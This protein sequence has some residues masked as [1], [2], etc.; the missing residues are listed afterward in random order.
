MDILSIT[1]TVLFTA[2]VTTVKDL[3]IAAVRAGAD[4]YG[5]NLCGADLRGANLYG[6]NLYGA[7]LY[8]ANLYGAK[9]ASLAFAIIQFIPEEG[10]FIGWK[11]CQNGVIVKL[12]I[13][14]DAKRSHG[15]ERKCRASKVEVVE[16]IGGEVGIS[17][18]D[19]KTVYRKGDT[20]VS[21]SFDENRWE[22][23]APGIHFFLTKAEAENYNG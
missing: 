5:A 9:N 3:L 2:A 12:S 6:A 4:L 13:P 8:G 19:N 20:V 15:T 10:A 23:C 16:V 18:R 1:G 11:K 17:M 7:N 22:V 14:E 21:D